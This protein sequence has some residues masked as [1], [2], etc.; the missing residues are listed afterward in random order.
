MIFSGWDVFCSQMPLLTIDVIHDMLN[1]FITLAEE[2]SQNNLERWEFLNA[3]SGC[4]VENPG[5]SV[6]VDAY[7]KGI[8]DYNI[9]KLGI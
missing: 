1:S 6:L 7:K 2:I 8:I 9:E 5:I 4:M 3:Y